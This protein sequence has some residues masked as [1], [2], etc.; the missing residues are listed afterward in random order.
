MATPA[1]TSCVPASWRRTATRSQLGKSA[2]TG[3]DL[4]ALRIP[5]YGLWAQIAVIEGGPRPAFWRSCDRL[6]RRYAV[7]P[8]RTAFV[9]GSPTE[10]VGRLSSQELQ[11]L[12][13]DTTDTTD[14]SLG[15]KGRDKAEGG[16]GP[17][18]RNVH[19]FGNEPPPTPGRQLA[20]DAQAPRTAFRMGSSP[21][22]VQRVLPGRGV[23]RE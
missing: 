7:S 17:C 5:R 22:Q 15:G 20:I 12:Q 19:S 6:L 8:T 2:S 21:R 9:S 1:S 23:N 16:T 11:I 18:M 4:C 13:S 14:T 10:S 3:R